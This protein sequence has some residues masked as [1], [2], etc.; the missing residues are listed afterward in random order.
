M[1]SVQK[2]FI[3]HTANMTGG[4]SQSIRE[5]IQNLDEKIDYW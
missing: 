3:I 5:L 2:L 4:G 1:N